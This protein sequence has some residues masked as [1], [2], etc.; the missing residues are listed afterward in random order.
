MNT[1][2]LWLI[3]IVLAIVTFLA[4]FLTA[5]FQHLAFILV[6]LL[7]VAV[8]FGWTIYKKVRS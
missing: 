3:F 8:G 2:K 5:K 1:G 4:T 7:I 6:W